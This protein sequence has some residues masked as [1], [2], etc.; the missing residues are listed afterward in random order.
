MK[1]YWILTSK[2]ALITYTQMRS[3]SS[4]S[5]R[6]GP[7]DEG[8]IYNRGVDFKRSGTKW[9]WLKFACPRQSSTLS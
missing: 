8:A 1:V 6:S 9:R 3:N 7:S 2:C 5:S 4:S